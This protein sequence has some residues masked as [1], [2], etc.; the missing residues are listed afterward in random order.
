MRTRLISTVGTSLLNNLKS[1]KE[2][3]IQEA[4]KY[5]K[6]HQIALLLVQR[7]NS[8]RLCG[9]EINSIT[10]ICKKEFIEKQPKLIFLLSDT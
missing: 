3:A 5:Q 9:A 1:S 8:D 6:W 4:F 2:E 7:E 10:S